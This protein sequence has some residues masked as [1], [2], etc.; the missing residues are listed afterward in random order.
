MEKPIVLI[1][2]ANGRIGKRLI[3]KFADSFTIIATDNEAPEEVEFENYFQMDVTES[4]EQCLEKIKEKFGSKIDSVIHL[5]AYYS[6]ADQ[7]WKKYQDITIEGTKKLIRNFK[8]HFQLKQFIFSSTLLVYEQCKLGE[9]IAEDSPLKPGWEYPRSK[10]ITEQ[11]LH[12]ENEDIHLVIFRIAGCYDDYCNS[13]PISQQIS[14]I[15]EKQFRK[16]FFSGNIDH[17]NSFLHLDDLAEAFFSAV[18]KREDLPHEVVIILGEPKSYSYDSLQRKLGKLILHKEFSTYSVPKFFAK[19]VVW[20]EN[21]LPFYPTPFIQ[22]WMID[23]ADAHYEVDITLA[24]NLLDWS[25]KR[26]LYET[27]P[28]MVQA[29]KKD[30]VQWYKNHKLTLK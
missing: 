21:H 13:I 22:P 9:K 16:Q 24:K 29:L 19:T 3:K 6:F 17:G 12:D 7:D 11:S 1:T 26:D 4:I 18:Q 14:R 25:P 27:L 8:K 20:I 28:L 30:P 15:Y 23:I 5:A 10:V 2:G